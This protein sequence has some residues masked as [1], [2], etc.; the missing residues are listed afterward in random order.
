MEY[1]KVD[2]IQVLI[3]SSLSSPKTQNFLYATIYGYIMGEVDFGGTN[4]LTL[5][6]SGFLWYLMSDDNLIMSSDRL[7]KMDNME[8]PLSHYFVA[9]SHNTYLTGHQLT[10]RAGVEMYRQV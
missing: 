9:S 6:L 3:L 2:F 8:L 4:E 1:G 7:Y 10:G 5:F